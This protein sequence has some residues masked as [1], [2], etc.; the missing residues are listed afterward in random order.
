MTEFLGF[1]ELRKMSQSWYEHNLFGEIINIH[2]FE[3]GKRR[4]YRFRLA[5]CLDADEVTP[6][7]AIKVINKK[8][9]QCC[10]P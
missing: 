6:I 10:V 3:D 9:H 2:L 7:N 1:T 4:T 8:T 5:Q